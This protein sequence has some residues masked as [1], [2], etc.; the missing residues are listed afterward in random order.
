ML[1]LY[2]SLVT[3]NPR[4]WFNSLVKWKQWFIALALL[5]IVDY[6]STHLLMD[7]FGYGVE[8][9]PFMLWVTETFDTPVAIL[10][11]KALFLTALFFY[12][13]WRVGA[14]RSH[15]IA[16]NGLVFLSIAFGLVSLTNMTIYFIT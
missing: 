8:R 10:V 12:L 16:K 4:T 3:T 2:Y 1:K 5:N 9:N 6:Q 15:K 11:T 14:P 7:R 13:D